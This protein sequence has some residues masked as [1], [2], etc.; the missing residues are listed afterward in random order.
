[1]ANAVQPTT[2]KAA[3]DAILATGTL[4]AYLIDT[5]AYT[6]SAA[7]DFLADIPGAARVGTPITLA[8]VTTTDGVL[9]ADDISFTGLSGAPTIEAV[10]LCVDT[11]DEATSRFLCYIDTATGLPVAAGQSTV[12]IVWANT[13]NRIFKL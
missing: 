2:K 10:A 3:L 13:S 6:Y 7:H 8:N 1:M 5:A 12:N 9:D 4:K 11:G